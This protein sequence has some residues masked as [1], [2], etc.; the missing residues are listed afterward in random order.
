MTVNPTRMRL[1]NHIASRFRII[2][3]T[4]NT[5]IVAVRPAPPDRIAFAGRPCESVMRTLNM[6]NNVGVV[7]CAA[8]L[9][10][11]SHEVIE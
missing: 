10:A 1:A 4:I 2:T 3:T 6:R 7:L 11:D 9:E 5:R 8:G